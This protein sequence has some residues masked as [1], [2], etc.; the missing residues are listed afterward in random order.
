MAD[1]RDHQ[2]ITIDEFNGLWKRGDAD[3]CPPDHFSDCNNIRY[4]QSS[5]T[6]R[7][8]LTPY[9]PYPN[10]VRMYT[11]T[12][13]NIQSILAL[14]NHGNIWDIDYPANPIL[15][16]S[17]MTDFAFVAYA[18]RAYISPCD[19]KT[20]LN[21][22]FLYVYLGNGQAARKA[23]GEKP[24]DSDGALAAANS[25]SAGNV[26][27][28]IHIF[29]CVYETNT[30]FLTAIGPQTLPALTAPGNEKVN[31]T[32]IPVSPNSYVTK[33]HLIATKSINPDTYTGDT[34]GYQFFFI[35]DGVINDNT[36]TTLTVDF[37]DSQLLEDASYLLD[38][39]EEIPAFVGLNTYHNRLVGWGEYLNQSVI[40]ISVSGEP[41]AINQVD[42]LVIFPLDDKPVT[43]A[44]EYRD[45][46]YAFKETQT[47]GWADNGDVPSSWQL[48][49]VDHGMGASLHSVAAVLDSNGVNIDYLLIGN[50][51]GIHIF[52]GAY[53][54]PALTWKIEDLWLALDQAT[55]NKI[56]IVN[57]TIDKIFYLTLA[58]GT[59]LSGNWSLGLDAK[60]I[61]WTP[62]SSEIFITT[63]CLH[64]ANRLNLGS[65]GY[66]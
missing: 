3:S 38:M 58:D 16:I 5:F 45:V 13:V 57:N 51:S 29:A 8:G 7:F 50:Y 49:I 64:N 28:G 15:T 34:T 62:M 48:T 54:V 63:L 55:Y 40:R 24:T 43:N 25:G 56:Q 21:N 6:T 22:D 18:G 53:Q 37:F 9:Q 42:G 31:L 17:G 14:D 52:N 23:A 33:R 65:N 36:A 35:P 10:I 27:A 60:S 41:E 66:R 44:A 39:Y 4:S 61:R 32:N 12:K 26:E 59:M 19:G 46:L 1:F 47:V 20:G 11:Y 2:S 30:G